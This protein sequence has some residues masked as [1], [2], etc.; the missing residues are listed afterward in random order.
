MK[1]EITVADEAL[2]DED[3]LWSDGDLQF[4]KMQLEERLKYALSYDFYYEDPL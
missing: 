1:D 2:I 4:A 3:H